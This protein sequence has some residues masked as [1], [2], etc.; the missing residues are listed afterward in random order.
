MQTRGALLIPWLAVAKAKGKKTVRQVPKS[1][2]TWRRNGF[3]HL[4]LVLAMKFAAAKLQVLRKKYPDEAS[5]LDVYL[6]CNPNKPAALIFYK[7]AGFCDITPNPNDD[8]GFS[9]M[10]FTGKALL[11]Q[12]QCKSLFHKPDEDGG[13]LFLLLHLK[14]GRDEFRAPSHSFVPDQ[15]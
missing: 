5:Q 9:A 13:N 10:D 14:V 11:D 15:L 2:S 12:S 6:Q 7:E 8:N 4:M 1:L 3:G